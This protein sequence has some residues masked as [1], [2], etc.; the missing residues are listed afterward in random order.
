MNIVLAG[1]CGVGKSTVGALLAAALDI[2]FV[3][4]DDLRSRYFPEDTAVDQSP[5]SA[6]HLELLKCL[7][8]I[9]AQ[10]PSGFLLAIGGDTVFRRGANN[11]E[12]LLSVGYFKQETNAFIAVLTADRDILLARFSH[13]GGRTVES[14]DLPWLDWETE[15][16]RF[17][18][19]CHDAWL[20]TSSLDAEQVVGSIAGE[21]HGRR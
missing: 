10:A 7:P 12:R 20:D 5:F 17:W 18:W 15:A 11:D 2:G 1:P 6:S 14:F 8:A 3:D 9:R 19:L 21:L 4:F 16:K 13:K